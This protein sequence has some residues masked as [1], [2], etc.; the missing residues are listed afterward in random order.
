MAEY[1]W[2]DKTILVAEDMEMNFVLLKKT[3]EQTKAHIIRAK[4]GQEMVDII[5]SNSEVDIV[6]LDM[7]MPVMDG[8]EATKLLRS[9]GYNIPIIAQTAFALN[10][11]KERV[12][13]IGCNDYVEKPIKKE[14]LFEKI[15][16]LIN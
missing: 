9:E 6:L 3:L 15:D 12:L 2:K 14:I 13:E 1:N 10:N 5:K 8:Y 11:E 16:R 4:N 7:G